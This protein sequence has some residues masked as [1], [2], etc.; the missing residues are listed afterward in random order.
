[1]LARGGYSVHVA[2][3]RESRAVSVRSPFRTA[4]ASGVEGIVD[5]ASI[6]PE[7]AEVLAEFEQMNEDARSSADA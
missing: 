3:A 1:M 7:I 5:A 2:G 4:E 6:E